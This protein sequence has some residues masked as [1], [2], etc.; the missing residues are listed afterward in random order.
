MTRIKF[1]GLTRE[2][3][4]DTAAELGIDAVGFVLW[5]DSPRGISVDAAAR[6]IRR[7]PSS[8]TPVGVFVRPTREEI[9]DAV[10]VAGIR[11]AQLHGVTDPSPLRSESYELWIATSLNGSPSDIAADMMILLDAQDG[12]R[13]GG[14][15]RTIDWDAARQIAS[16]RRVMLAGGLTPHNVAEAIERAQPY[17]VDVSSGIEDQPGLKNA[18]LMREFARAART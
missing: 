1:C 12:E 16:T 17:G 15:G 4:V 3:D 2:A 5:P 11:V 18:T 7:L 9:D 10:E 6:L 8:I 14:T 13:H